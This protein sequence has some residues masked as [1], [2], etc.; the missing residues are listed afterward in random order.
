MD[1]LEDSEEEEDGGDTEKANMS[2]SRT[3]LP[4]PEGVTWVTTCKICGSQHTTCLRVD[5]NCGLRLR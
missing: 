5:M 4:R 2:A 3:G 1:L